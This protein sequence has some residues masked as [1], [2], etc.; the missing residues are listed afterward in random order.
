MSEAQ[1]RLLVGKHCGV[2]ELE[3]AGRRG[4]STYDEGVILEHLRSATREQH[5]R[6][7]STLPLGTDSLTQQDYRRL[8]CLFWG[9]Y[10]T[11]EKEAAEHASGRLRDFVRDRAKLPLL[12]A[13]LAALGLCSDTLPRLEPGC[14]PPFVHGDAVVLGSMYVLEGATLGGQVISR[15]LERCFGF[16]QGIGYSFFQ[17]YGKAVGQQWRAFLRSLEA[18]PDEQSEAV[19]AA[20]QQTFDAFTAWFA[21]GGFDASVS[22]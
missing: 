5:Q 15:S 4:L 9:F 16:S 11:W 1:V 7:E 6:L 3:C 10:A 17:S 13:D 8:V 14:L 2:V 20:A 19:A 22:K 12:Q 21:V 18:L